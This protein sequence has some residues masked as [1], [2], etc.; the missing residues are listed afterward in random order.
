M[1]LLNLSAGLLLPWLGGTLWLALVENR[2]SPES[3]PNRLR[4]AGYGFFL[5]Y[6]V[7]FL[8]IMAGHAWTGEV[9]WGWIMLFLL[10]FAAS[11]SLLLWFNPT[12]RLPAR[13]DGWTSLT[14]AQK[15][16]IIALAAW[17]A[18]HLLFVANEVL[19]Q[20]VFPWDA[21]QTWIY[22]AKAWFLSGGL[23]EMVSPDQWAAATSPDIYAVQG[24]EYPL[25]PSVIPYWAAL[26]LGRWSETLV[27]LPAL[28][29]GLAIGMALYGQ[30]R[31]AGMNA[32]ISLAAC[33]LLYSIP[34]FATHIAL[35]GYADLWMAGF[36]GLGFVALVRGAISGQGFQTALGFL[37]LGLSLLVKNEGAVWLLAAFLMQAL[38]TFRWRTNLIAGLILVAL[39][40]ASF[41]LGVT[42]V[43]LPLAGTF[44]VVDGRL[45]IPFIGRF[46]LEVHDVRQVYLDNFFMMGSWNL[47]WLLV[48]ASLLFAVVGRKPKAAHEYRVGAVFIVIF[49]ATQLFI[50]G[51]TNQGAWAD[52]YTAINRLPLHFLPALLFA[53][54]AICNARLNGQ[55]NDLIGAGN[56]ESIGFAG[57]WRLTAAGVIS[58][59]IVFAGA[60]GFL[61]RDL[62]DQGAETRHFDIEQ[63]RFMM[64]SGRQVEDKLVIEGFTNGYALVSSGPVR[65]PSAIYRYL[66]VNL[67]PRGNSKPPTF[68]WRDS[69]SPEELVQMTLREKGNFMVDLTQHP[70]W[71]GEISEVGVLFYEDRDTFPALSPIEL[72]PDSLHLRLQQLWQDW[73]AFEHWTQKSVN[74]L[75]GGNAS[76]QIELSML[77]IAWLLL[78]LA[79]NRLFQQGSGGT[80]PR[81][82]VVVAALLF[83]G[84]WALL[85]LRWSGNNLR[86][87][88]VTV[89]K[90]WGSDEQEK[91][92]RGLDGE[93]FR[94][95]ERLKSQTLTRQISRVL[96]VGDETA[97]DYALLRAK[98]HLLPHSVHV[99]QQLSSNLETENLDY[100]HF[101]GS[102]GGFSGVPGWNAE[103]NRRLKQ[104]DASQLGE[105]YEVQ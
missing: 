29:A 68:F 88:G 18:L 4:Q 30:C 23:A 16:L 104:V 58:A 20:P 98:Y 28:L 60:L 86:Q 46:A 62:P 47:L 53:S 99:V 103:L 92:D 32:L 91:L 6:A 49:L 93:L 31:E 89:G 54:L 38:V 39:V 57:P 70:R 77:L 105:V 36:A 65:V 61:A 80:E 34:L 69:D 43:E 81:R 95:I 96:V 35:A 76:R 37:L 79:L 87:T 15:W 50:F 51:F 55:H 71:R 63:L 10:L 56:S 17:T 14:T 12:R 78:A 27:N 33:Y 2:L 3:Q 94:E 82:L 59:V 24:A 1:P 83:L 11:G 73:T 40:S 100:V 85:D 72:A 8:T 7:L 9:S 90:Y 64:G 66:R 52:T 48:A 13:R 75:W 84:A 97:S 41:A 26:S 22:R 45:D 44:G 42:H 19:N 74:F 5:G 102:P 21:W 101:L 25:L 67:D